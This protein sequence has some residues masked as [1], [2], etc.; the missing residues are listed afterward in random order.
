ML[1]FSCLTI[2]DISFSVCII[3]LGVEFHTS[4]VYCTPYD[5]NTHKQLQMHVNPLNQ[6]KDAI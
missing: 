6:T 3:K 4:N 5:Y 1:G 2:P